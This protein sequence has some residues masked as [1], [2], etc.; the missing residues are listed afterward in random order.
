M[1]GFYNGYPNTRPFTIRKPNK[2]VLFG[3][4]S[5]IEPF[6]NRTQIEH[7]NTGLVQYCD[8]YC[9]CMVY[10]DWNRAFLF[11]TIWMLNTWNWTTI[12]V[13]SPLD[14]WSRNQ[15]ENTKWRS[16]HSDSSTTNRTIKRFGQFVW[17]SH[18]HIICLPAVISYG[19][20]FVLVFGY[21][22]CI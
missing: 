1:S 14:Y 7:L 8:Q 20:C 5:I 19:F 6:N 13:L 3:C 21:V 16:Y 4:R 15:M 9:I 10:F 11:W 12:K 18:G 17:F 2:F 22:F